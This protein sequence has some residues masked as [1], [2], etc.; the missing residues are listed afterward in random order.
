MVQATQ[1]GQQSN[2][3]TIYLNEKLINIGDWD[4][5]TFTN[6]EGLE[7]IGNPLPEGVIEKDE[8]VITNEDGSRSI[9]T[10]SNSVTS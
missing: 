5:Q 10:P 8:E 1:V 3:K 4:Y 7:V 6:L 9:V 2:M